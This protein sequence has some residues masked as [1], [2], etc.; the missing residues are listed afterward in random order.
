MILLTTQD[1][2]MLS[3]EDFRKNLLRTTLLIV[4]LRDLKASVGP[5]IA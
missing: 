5:D 1:F 3:H 2:P 4:G